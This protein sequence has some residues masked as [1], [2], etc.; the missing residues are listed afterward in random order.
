MK[1]QKTTFKAGSKIRLKDF[2]T[3]ATSGTTKE[4]AQK[5]C[6]ENSAAIGNLSYRL[7]AENQRALLISL[8]GMDTCREGWRHPTYHA[9]CGRAGHRGVP[10]QET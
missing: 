8:Q 1:L 2:D 9:Q 7:Y 3:R 5:I 4:D 10:L 6:E